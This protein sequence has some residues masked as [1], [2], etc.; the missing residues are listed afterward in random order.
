MSL[1]TDSN[2]RVHKEGWRKWTHSIMG[3]RCSEPVSVF[4]DED[5]HLSTHPHMPCILFTFDKD[6][7]LPPSDS[8]L[9]DYFSYIY[10]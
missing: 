2:L 5:C 6:P 4:G 3:I 1:D 7:I 10:F 9:E 8:L